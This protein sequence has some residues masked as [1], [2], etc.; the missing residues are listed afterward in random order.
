MGM[1][2]VSFHPDETR[3]GIVGG[4]EVR[5]K[6][7]AVSL[8]CLFLLVFGLVGCTL[9]N[10]PRRSLSELRIALLNHD[11]DTAL[12]YVDVDSVVDALVRDVFRKHEAKMDN[13]IA[14]LGIKAG[15]EAADV[16][17]PGL[18][19]ITRW[20]LRT[21]ITSDD[22]W[23]YFEDIKKSS[24]WYLNIEVEGDVAFVKPKGK[25]DIG[26]RMART[27]DGHWKIVEMNYPAP[28]HGGS[29]ERQ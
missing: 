7:P 1:R 23:G 16:V 24:V 22:Q 26:F 6:G 13:P 3:S 8:L 20:Q 28:R 10:T 5:K 14:K 9:S 11:A 29:R 4:F 27:S 12:R 2:T 21:A 19:A 18:V 25:S 15:K 17:M